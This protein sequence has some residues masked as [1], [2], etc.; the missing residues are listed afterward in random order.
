MCVGAG[1]IKQAHIFPH[2]FLMLLFKN[3]NLGEIIPLLG[4]SIN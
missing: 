2:S 4:S 3:S 1:G